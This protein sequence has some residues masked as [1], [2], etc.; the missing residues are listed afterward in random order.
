[1]K[2]L[3]LIF[4][5][6]LSAAAFSHAQETDTSLTSQDKEKKNEVVIYPNPATDLVT[7]KLPSHSH[8][9]YA[10]SVLNIIGLPQNVEQEHTDNRE[11]RLRI[12]DLPTGYYLLSVQGP[13]EYRKM[14]KFLKK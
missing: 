5:F 10:V 3:P 14:F 8:E 4:F 11:I 1:M 2:I 12:K 7:V 9:N 6:A 13:N